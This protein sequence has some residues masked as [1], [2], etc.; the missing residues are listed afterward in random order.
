MCRKFFFKLILDWISHKI[1]FMMLLM[2]K[3]LMQLCNLIIKERT[4]ICE[5]MKHS[6]FDHLNSFSRKPSQYW[7]NDT[8]KEYFEYGL[9]LSVLYRL[10]QEKRTVQG[11]AAVTQTMYRHILTTNSI[12]VFQAQKGCMWWMCSVY[13]ENQS[14][15][16]RKGA[17]I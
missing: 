4:Q 13:E 7:R 3:T 6:I 14:H 15:R 10:Y 5:E 11:G 12:S 8:N 9:N 1:L 2:K 17:Y 16:W